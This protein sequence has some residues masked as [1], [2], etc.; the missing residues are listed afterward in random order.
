[1]SNDSSHDSTTSVYNH[2]TDFSPTH[3]PVDRTYTKSYSSVVHSKEGPIKKRSHRT[4]TINKRPGI[5]SYSSKL[6]R[7]MLRGAKQEKVIQMYVKNIERE[8]NENETD[9]EKKVKTYAGKGGVKVMNVHVVKNYFDDHIVGCKI[10]IPEGQKS[11]VENNA[12]WPKEFNA[13]LGVRKSTKIG[14]AKRGHIK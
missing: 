14:L 6:T 4:S 12:F 9:I 13:G 5:G 8:E 7:I 1:M 11:V 10:K 2:T 3:E